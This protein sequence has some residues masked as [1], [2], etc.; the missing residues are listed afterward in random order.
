M[1]EIKLSRGFIA[2]VDDEDY[3]RLIGYNW[4][5]NNPKIDLYY[6]VRNNKR[7]LKGVVKMHREILGFPEGFVDHIVHRSDEKIIDNRKSNLRVV[8]RSLN[9]ANMRKRAGCSSQFKGVSQ[10]GSKWYAQIMQDKKNNYL[11]LFPTEA[12]AARAH[13]L[14]AVRLFGENALTNF[15]VPGSRHWLFGPG[16]S[17]EGIAQGAL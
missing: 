2:L 4:S 12:L 15:N 3:D 1:R 16:G 7:P 10:R 5:A 17:G 14:V 9:A 13:D 11:G 6:A 8:T